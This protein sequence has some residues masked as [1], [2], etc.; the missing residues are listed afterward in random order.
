MRVFQEQNEKIVNGSSAE[1][2]A[3]EIHLDTL[4]SNSEMNRT[5]V[6]DVLT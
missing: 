2:G 3:H 5:F 1:E 6:G 4:A